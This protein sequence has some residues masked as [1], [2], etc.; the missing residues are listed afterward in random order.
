[1]LIFVLVFP[2]YKGIKSR[3][4][5]KGGADCLNLLDVSELLFVQELVKVADEL[6]ED[7]QVL[8]APVVG[9]VVQLIEVHQVRKHDSNVLYVKNH[10]YRHFCGYNICIIYMYVFGIFYTHTQI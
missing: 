3:R 6:V 5:H 4:C 7:A 1:M 10:K 8:L 2:A 9:L